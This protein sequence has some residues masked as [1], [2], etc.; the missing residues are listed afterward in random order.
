MCQPQTRQLQDSDLSAFPQLAVRGA[1][2]HVSVLRCFP[3]PAATAASAL[4]LAPAI[5]AASVC[6]ARTCTQY[7]FI[8]FLSM[9]YFMSVHS[10]VILDMYTV[11]LLYQVD[12]PVCLPSELELPP[13]GW[14]KCCWTELNWKYRKGSNVFLCR[15]DKIMCPPPPPP[16][17]YRLRTAKYQ[18][19]T[20]Q[21]RTKCGNC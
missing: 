11:Q 16:P 15:L 9:F 20:F 4:P 18:E 1:A 13:V 14:L 19:Q 6:S 12:N 21:I 2:G 5:P 17:P 3:S 10:K 8:F 7:F